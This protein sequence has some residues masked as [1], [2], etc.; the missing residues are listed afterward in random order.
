MLEKIVEYQAQTHGDEKAKALL[1]SV[2]ARLETLT[3]ALINQLEK[4]KEVPAAIDDLYA[5]I[6]KP[7][8]E[9]VARDGTE[10]ERLRNEV[11]SRQDVARPRVPLQ[12][13]Y[14]P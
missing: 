9:R 12:P 6:L 2:A 8:D 14:L 4:P 13:A 11:R 3:E 10:A 5:E 7:A 1:A